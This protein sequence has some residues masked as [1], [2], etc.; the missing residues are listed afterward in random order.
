MVDNPMELTFDD[1]LARPQVERYIT[2]SCVSNRVGGDLVG[3]A[4]WQG[5]LLQ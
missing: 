4:L 2:L 5:V 3:N 1:L